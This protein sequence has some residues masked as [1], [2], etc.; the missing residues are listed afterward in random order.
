VI[1]EGRVNLLAWRDCHLEDVC[2]RG[3]VVFD[4]PFLHKT[5]GH[6][7]ARDFQCSPS[8][9]WVHERKSRYHF[10]RKMQD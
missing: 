10:S 2:E 6:Q 4:S 5:L 8:D 7:L 3:W 1:K 9:S